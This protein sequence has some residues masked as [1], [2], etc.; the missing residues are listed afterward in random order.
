MNIMAGKFD[1]TPKRLSFDDVTEQTDLNKLKIGHRMEIYNQFINSFERP[2]SREKKE[3]RHIIKSMKSTIE[4]LLS[5][6]EKL[7]S[8]VAT[9]ENDQPTLAR[10][11][12]YASMADCVKGT[13]KENLVII[14]AEKDDTN[15]KEIVYG[16]L[17]EMKSEIDVKKIKINKSNIVIDLSNEQQQTK[18]IERMNEMPNVKSDK[19]RQMIPSILIKEIPR[20]EKIEEMNGEAKRD[21]YKEYL[22]NE[23][24]TNLKINEMSIVVRAVIDKS[25]FRT[26]RAI[27]NFDIETTKKVLRDEQIKIGYMACQIERT[28]GLIQCKHCWRFGHFAND[29]AGNRTC[30]SKQ[31]CPICSG[32]HNETECQIKR[33]REFNKTKCVNCEGNHTAFS[34]LCKKRTEEMNK[35]LA[36]SVC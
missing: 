26:I 10:N 3:H 11:E 16:K 15:L 28:C 33:N 31:T 2:N 21:R 8:Q 4:K 32:E 35:L 6:N 24:A 27:V 20:V 5:E 14:K 34:A 13:K 29:K 12:K 30:K 1:Q 17:N 23:I 18:L 9:L 25:K 19:P 7:K 36:K 22:R